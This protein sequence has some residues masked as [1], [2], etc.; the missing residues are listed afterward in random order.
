[1]V[2]LSMSDDYKGESGLKSFLEEVSD[3]V[4]NEIAVIDEMEQESET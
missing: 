1:M 4:D 3:I 2:A